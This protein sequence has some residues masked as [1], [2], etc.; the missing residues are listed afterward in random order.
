MTVGRLLAIILGVAVLLI[1]GVVGTVY[2]SA[3]RAK[4]N[5]VVQTPPAVN[6]LERVFSPTPGVVPT[7]PN[8][9][10]RPISGATPAPSSP[11]APR[12]VV[13]ADNMK[14]VQI[15]GVSFKYPQNWGLL[16][17]TNSSN[18]EFDPYSVTDQRMSCDRAQKPITVLVGSAQVCP[19]NTV[20]LGKL[21]V[22]KSKVENARGVDYRWCFSVDGTHFDITH[23]VSQSGAR[24]T[25]KDDFSTQIEQMI[26]NIAPNQPGGGS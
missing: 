23:R 15:K 24:A 21:Q 10:P 14:M 11:V 13:L 1:I 26:T 19:G 2:Y 12:P 5:I 3:Q 6:E 7:Q 20:N 22:I 4:R 17:C 9:P 8:T 16:T 18:F 25:S